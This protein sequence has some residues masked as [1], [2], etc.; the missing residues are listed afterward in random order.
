MNAYFIADAHIAAIRS[1]VS[2]NRSKEL[3]R[4][5]DSISENC[6]HLFIVGDLFDFWFEYKTVV[7]ATPFP[8]LFKLK[9]MADTGIELCMLAGNHD[10]ALGNFFSDEIGIQVYMHPLERELGGKRFYIAHGDGLN[11]KD[12]GYRLI[13]RII[14]HPLSHTLFR[15][16]HPDFGIQLAHTLSFLS[17][18]HRPVKDRDQIYIDFAKKKF[19]ENFDCVVLGHT[20][21]PQYFTENNKTYINTGD[22]IESF[23]YGHFDGQSLR[24]SQWKTKINQE[25]G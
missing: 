5:L 18:N 12:I 24:L 8:V 1:E 6:T 11:P 19:E 3:I 17:R 4:F 7:P 14:R 2:R 15:F 10:F 23:T 9:Q 25:H 16:L 22:W 13:K 20:H 21:R